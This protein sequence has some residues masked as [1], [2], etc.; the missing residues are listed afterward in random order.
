VF[1]TALVLGLVCLAIWFAAQFARERAAFIARLS[2][3]QRERLKGFETVG[4]D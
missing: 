2:P 3:L 1:W 4:G